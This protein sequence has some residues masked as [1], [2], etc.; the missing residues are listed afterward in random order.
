MLSST[1]TGESTVLE[2]SHPKI[3]GEMCISVAENQARVSISN[4][5][6]LTENDEMPFLLLKKM[7]LVLL[8]PVVLQ[9]LRFWLL[10]TVMAPKYNMMH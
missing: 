7:A 1:D 3:R 10:Y 2:D 6:L 9:L 4:V 5:L 8:Q